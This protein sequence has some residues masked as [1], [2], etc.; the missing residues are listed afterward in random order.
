M[1]QATSL[2]RPPEFLPTKLHAG[3]HVIFPKH[4]LRCAVGDG[5]HNF[6]LVRAT[7]QHPS[8]ALAAAALNAALPEL[9]N[10]IFCDDYCTEGGLSMDDIDLWSRLRSVTLVKG[11]QFGPKTLKYLENLSARG[12]IPLYFSMAM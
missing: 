4:S 8:E 6:A 10:L 11:A 12:D 7:P 5:A 1:P 9:E 3:L 2:C